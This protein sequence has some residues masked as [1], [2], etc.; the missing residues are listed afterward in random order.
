MHLREIAGESTRRRWLDQNETADEPVW[1]GH[2]ISDL[3]ARNLVRYH[4]EE[5]EDAS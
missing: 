4:D 1:L 2:Q 3:A 5:N